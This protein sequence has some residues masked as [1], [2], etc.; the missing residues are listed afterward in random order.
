MNDEILSLL[1]SAALGSTRVST[2]MTGTFA[3]FAF[4]IAE[5]ISLEP[6]GVTM[7]AR[8]PV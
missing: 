2:T 7:S 3:R 5:A 8:M 4:A 1:S 6:L